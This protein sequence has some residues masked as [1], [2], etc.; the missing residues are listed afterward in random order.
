MQAL[1]L[2]PGGL[3]AVTFDDGLQQPLMSVAL[4]GEGE[5]EE[6]D[7]RFGAVTLRDLPVGTGQRLF[8]LVQ[9]A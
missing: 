7:V 4:C 8:R 1:G 6:V 3:L 9:Q 2:V 5:A